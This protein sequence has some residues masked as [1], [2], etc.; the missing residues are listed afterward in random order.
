[1]EKIK[2]YGICLYK[3]D[4]NRCKILLCK[5][6]KS[7]KRWGFL[8]GVELKHES[9]IQT[10]V[11]EFTE[12]SS[13]PIEKNILEDYIFQKNEFKDIG[14]YLAN[15]K[16]I[17]DINKYFHQDT[18]Y[19]G[20]LSCENSKVKFFD[21]DKLPLIKKKQEKIAKEIIEILTAN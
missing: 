11:R 8:K 14:I 15:A 5:S 4:K 6:V 17:E 21:I 9:I 19:N 7:E 10:A 3:K 13:I 1:M 12:E 20:Y 16:H 2:A 18:L